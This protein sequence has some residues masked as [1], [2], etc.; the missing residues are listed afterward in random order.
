MSKGKLAGIIVACTIAIIVVIFIVPPKAPNELVAPGTTPSHEELEGIKITASDLFDEYKENEIAADQN[1]KNHVLTTVGE[2]TDIGKDPQMEKAYVSVGG[3][4]YITREWIRCFFD[5]EDDLLG[6]AE[7]EEVIVRGKCLGE[8]EEEDATSFPIVL[9]NCSLLEETEFELIGWEI[10]PAVGLQVGYGLNIRFTKF[11]YSLTFTMINPKGEEIP[12]PVWLGRGVRWDYTT[13]WKDTP[14]LIPLTKNKD[15]NY[16]AGQYQLLVKDVKGNTVATQTFNFSGPQLEVEITE[17]SGHWERDVVSTKYNVQLHEYEPIYGEQC[18]YSFTVA[19][20]IQNGGDLPCYSLYVIIKSPNDDFAE[21]SGGSGVVSLEPG[22]E[23]TISLSTQYYKEYKTLS[24]LG[25]KIY[26][27]GGPKSVY[28]RSPGEKILNFE[29]CD[30]SGMVV[31]SI[32]TTITV[33]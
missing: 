17:V 16:A 32:N 12:D 33:P 30:E 6:L 26:M 11:G 3:G 2:I 8:K 19:I 24:A 25:N 9:E 20:H 22:E 18:H 28:F 5:N 1:Y 29:F 21:E 23:E 13:E 4:E 10:G 7:G 15:E 14:Y 31:Y 27:Q